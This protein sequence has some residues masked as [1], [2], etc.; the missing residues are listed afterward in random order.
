MSRVDRVKIVRIVLW[1]LTPVVAWA[2]AFLGGWIGAMAAGDGAG[3]GP[4]VMGGVIGGA[5]GV[6]GWIAM[7][8][9]FGKQR[10]ED[11]D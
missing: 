2:A 8:V 6:S 1:L 10:T 4:L 9:W 5:F 3:V 7:L 11:S